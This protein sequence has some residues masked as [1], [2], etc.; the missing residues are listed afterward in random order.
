MKTKKIM[1]NIFNETEKHHS[2]NKL[3]IIHYKT[4]P[5]HFWKLKPEKLRT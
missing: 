3:K 4:L 2:E 1:A 5:V